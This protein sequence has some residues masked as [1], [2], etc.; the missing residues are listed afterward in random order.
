MGLE[1]IKH[2]GDMRS[3]E[4]M[5]WPKSECGGRF[6]GKRCQRRR[7]KMNLDAKKDKSEALGRSEDKRL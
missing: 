7:R 5:R 6:K 2:R 1:E 4:W 3:C